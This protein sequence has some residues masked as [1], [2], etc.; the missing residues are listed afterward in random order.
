M[1]SKYFL[2]LCILLVGGIFVFSVEVGASAELAEEGFKVDTIFLKNMV[3]QGENV[4]NMLRISDQSGVAS[5]FYLSVEGLDEMVDLSES[6]FEVGA[7]ESKEVKIIFRGNGKEPGVY[8]GKLII[9]SGEIRMIPIILEI[10]SENIL[11]ATNLEVGAKYSE[12]FPG[13]NIVVSTRLF[14]LNDTFLHD[15][16]MEY[17]VKSFDGETIISER[18]TTVVGTEVAISKNLILPEEAEVGNY[19]FIVVAKFGDSVST[20]SYLFNIVEEEEEEKEGFS[21]VGGISYFVL[22][23][24][25]LL[26]AIVV[27]IIYLMY[28]RNQMF[29]ELR[30]QNKSEMRM[31]KE[32]F[33]IKKKVF[34][35]KAK[36]SGA[37]REVVRKMS[38]ARGI[39]VRELKSRHKKQRKEF[40]KLSKN[41]KKNLMRQ[42]MGEWKN[43]GFK[44]GNEI[45]KM[46]FSEK[47]RKDQMGKWKGQGFKV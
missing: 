1:V 8:V 25:A 46:K 11:F 27:L 20:S 28:E 4:S 30:R 9:E 17:M 26:A 2:V 42:K 16:G 47:G 34:L 24:V 35:T 15:V 19:A 41:H 5:D 32:A 12:I 38:S 39:A 33:E 43:Q 36:T 23:I 3:K 14:N 7:G 21:F 13:G 37:R 45:R 10:Q 29:K 31:C 18:E 22:I 6:E 44:F 40:K